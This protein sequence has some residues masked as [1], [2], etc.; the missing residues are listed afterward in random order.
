MTKLESHNAKR[1][2]RLFYAGVFELK[3]RAWLAAHEDS[4][5]ISDEGGLLFQK[6]NATEAV[7]YF[8]THNWSMCTGAF[9]GHEKIVDNV[10]I[11]VWGDCD[12]ICSTMP[13]EFVHEI[14]RP[15]HL[16]VI[17]TEGGKASVETR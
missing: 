16:D 14:S 10:N 15:S 6:D 4:Y 17:G 7:K 13:S 1:L 9:I 3:H 2:Q 8:G 12:A 11:K 5:V